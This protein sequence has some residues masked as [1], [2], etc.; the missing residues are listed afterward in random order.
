VTAAIRL[1]TASAI[2][3]RYSADLRQLTLVRGEVSLD[4][5]G[6]DNRPFRIATR[7]AALATQ[8]GQLLLRENARGLLLAVR[9]GDVTLFPAS[10]A[11]HQVKPGEVLQVLATGAI[12]RPRCTV[13]PG[14]GPMACSAC[15]RCHWASSS[16]NCRATARACCAARRRWPG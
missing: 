1:N 14:A 10:A 12:N 13:T 16:T 15:S 8:G 2:D 5:N 4:S 3:L 6:N 11:A 9:R 7:F